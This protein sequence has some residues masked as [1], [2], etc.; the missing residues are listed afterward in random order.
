MTIALAADG[1]IRLDG[2]CPLEDAEELL[3]L[4]AA[5]PEAAVDW[6]TCSY[7]HTAVIQILLAA[8]PQLRGPPKDG[9]LREHIDAVLARRRD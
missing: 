4:L 5:N 7:A 8:G 3:R 1:T 6:R 2:D 9:F